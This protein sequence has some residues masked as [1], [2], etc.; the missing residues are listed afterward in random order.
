MNEHFLA[1][2]RGISQPPLL[3]AVYPPR[4]DAAALAGRL[5]GA[6][7]GQHTHQPA[8]SIEM[9]DGQTRQVRNRDAEIARP[10]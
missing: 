7:P 10:A 9:L 2:A 1:A 4:H 5:A 8:R 3:A 6:G